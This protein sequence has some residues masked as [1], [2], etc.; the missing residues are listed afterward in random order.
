MV[1]WND[2]PD[3]AGDLLL[4][5][6]VM[7]MQ[8]AS[9]RRRIRIGILQ[10]IF[11]SCLG[12]RIPLTA[13]GAGL[14][15]EIC[16]YEWSWLTER[17]RKRPWCERGWSNNESSTL[18][19]GPGLSFTA[20]GECI[21]YL[22]KWETTATLSHCIQTLNVTYCISSENAILWINLETVFDLFL[23]FHNADSCLKQ[24]FVYYQRVKIF[25][26]KSSQI[27]F[28][29][30]DIQFYSWLFST[31]ML[32]APV[33]IRDIS[34]LGVPFGSIPGAASSTYLVFDAFNFFEDLIQI[35][36]R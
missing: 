29:N 22:S 2:I 8:G 3:I 15:F 17:Q 35:W 5:Q 14:S 7:H 31:W 6:P 13:S 24:I 21:V 26:V 10:W 20:L 25:C 9:S 27:Q 4:L 36:N 28:S 16:D 32:Q 34:C 33:D 19:S 18:A 30:L 11:H 23:F 1:K 12:A